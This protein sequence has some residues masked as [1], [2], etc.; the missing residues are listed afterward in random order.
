MNITTS[1]RNSHQFLRIIPV[2]RAVLGFG[3]VILC[4]SSY[5]VIPVGFIMILVLLLS[6]I[7]IIKN[8]HIDARIKKS[9]WVILLP[10]ISL[11]LNVLSFIL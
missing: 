5:I 7:M 4:E 1:E 8:P 6:I 9:L 10:I 11:L 2:I 3:I